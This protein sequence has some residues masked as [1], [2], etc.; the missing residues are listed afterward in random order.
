[1]DSSEWDSVMQYISESS[2]DFPS[3]RPVAELAGI[4][5]PSQHPALQMLTPPCSENSPSSDQQ[6]E[7]P[8]QSS[9]AIVSVSTTFHP[10]ANLLQITPDLILL[11]SD[12][13]FFYV[14]TTQVLSMSNNHFNGMLSPTAVKAKTRDDLGL[15]LPLPEAATVLNIVLHAVYELSCAHYHPGIDTLIVAVDAMP[16]YGLRPSVHIAPSTPLYS[17]ILSQAPVQ[18]I[19]AYALAAA[20]DLYDLAV[21]VSSHLL[22][23]VLH[24]LTDEAATRIGPVYLK[25]L[26]F[27]HL[28]RLEAL[29][30][31]LLPPPHPH[32]PTADCDFTEQKKLTRA[33]ALASAYLAWDARP[34]TRISG[35]QNHRSILNMVIHQSTRV[36]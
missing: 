29:K 23:F 11:S 8:Q 30:R 32:S 35:F 4:P 33:W 15:V 14:H 7:A 25:R 36:S 12:G 34:G 26:F 31:L 9:N 27:L 3:P 28:G 21:P 24:T 10:G 19:N 5:L 1:M 6:D 20:H 2:P 18:P 13:V 17:L 16:T 22:S